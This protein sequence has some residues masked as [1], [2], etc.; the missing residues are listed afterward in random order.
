MKKLSAILLLAFLT[1]GMPRA[2]EA[3]V[4]VAPF[5]TS[6]PQF[7]D[8]SGS[9][10]ASG[11]VFTYAAGTTT[12]LV[13]YSDSAG[14]TPNSNPVILNSGG[15]PQAGGI[16]LTSAAYKF[17]VKSTGGSNCSTGST[18]TTTDGITWATAAQTFA[19]IVST[20]DVTLQQGTAA[21]SGANQSSNNLK[22]QAKY[23]N[24]SASATESCNLQ[25]V[26]GTGPNPTVAFTLTCSGSSGATTFSVVPNTAFSGNVSVAQTLSA[27]RFRGA[28]DAFFYGGLDA[29]ASINLAMAD[30]ACTSVE[31][32]NFTSPAAAATINATKP[33][34]LGAYT[35][36]GGA[37][38][39]PVISVGPQSTLAGVGMNY[40]IVTSTSNTNDIVK[41]PSASQRFTIH[42]LTITQ[43]VTRSAGAAL[44]MSGGNASVYNI[45]IPIYHDG[46]FFD[47]AITSGNNMVSN[48]WLG[49]AVDTGSPNCGIRIG[50]VSS[51][52]VS[53]N[54]FVNGTL[55]TS[56]THTDALICAQD[57][58]DTPLFSNIQAV[59][60]SVHSSVALHTEVVNGGTE[61]FAVHFVNSTFEGGPAANSVVIDKIREF[62]C[63]LCNEATG[64]IGVKINGGS[65][66]G[67]SRFHWTGGVIE[68]N[69][70]HGV[71]IEAG[72][73]DI[74][75][76]GVRFADNGKQTN[77]TFDHIFNVGASNF[78]FDYNNF[79]TILSSGPP[80]NIVKWNIENAASGCNNYTMSGNNFS[81]SG[82]SGTVSDGCSGTNRFV[83]NLNGTNPTTLP[84]KGI[85]LPEGANPATNAGNTVCNPNSSTHQLECSYNNGSFFRMTQTIGSGGV[86]TAG[87]AVAA[88]T[89]Q[90]QTGITVT[91]SLT[92][93][94][95]VANINAALP[96]TWQTGIRW[97]AEVSAAG[98]CTVNLCN[99]TA[100]SITPAQTAIRCVVT[101]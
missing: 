98:T 31:A 27:E 88:G 71:D 96:A 67:V 38:A 63:F 95:A 41:A 51:G 49:N 79:D 22:V 83:V 92:T 66:V 57:G 45:Y 19:G 77:N 16:W 32:I 42:D 3:Q 55:L 48:F 68:N 75:F 34:L 40:S 58:T 11:C 50:G 89:C 12:P 13:T 37:G 73:G 94:Q 90:A 56:A 53:S 54:Q 80:A 44:R 4:T 99:P 84:L 52:T 21:T 2:A 36:T 91:G 81:G 65:S 23:W 26:L 10:L 8:G 28:C 59:W 1:F 72:I 39:N 6:N 18:I 101:R 20:G 76:I 15:F 70:Q 25:D 93:D 69:Q 74:S 47:T 100:G 82:V 5:L 78:H 33:L 29:G 62:T 85:Q 7:L 24:G 9:P 46:M 87:T 17:V 35:L 61:P 97:S 43:P 60:D 86:N 30:S 14:S 64:N